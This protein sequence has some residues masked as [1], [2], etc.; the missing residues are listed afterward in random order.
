MER[1]RQLRQILVLIINNVINNNIQNEFLTELDN[2]IYEINR[3]VMIDTSKI[4]PPDTNNTLD[5]KLTILFNEIL[6][7]NIKISDLWE[8]PLISRILNDKNIPGKKSTYK[9]LTE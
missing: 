7:K 1:K 8:Y 4:F 9:I 5:I 2:F 6:N 3:M